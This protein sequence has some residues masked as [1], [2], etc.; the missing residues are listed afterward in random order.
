LGWFHSTPKS[1]PSNKEKSICR[2]EKIT[3]NGGE[4]LMPPVDADYLIGYW[5]DLG[6]VGAGSMGAVCLS[7]SEI[8][9]WCDLSAVELEPWEFTAL[10]KMSQSYI[11]LLNAGENPSEPPPY[12]TLAQ[13]YDR[14]V[15][16]K[17]VSNAFKS[18]MMAGR[19]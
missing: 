14:D 13:E 1:D 4:P 11:T 5:H 6:L 7:S 2:V 17:K 10:R 9:A 19:K 3:N 8:M 15:V 12:G 16:Q 18:F